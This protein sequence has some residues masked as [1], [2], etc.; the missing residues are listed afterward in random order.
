MWALILKLLPLLIKNL[1]LVI[2]VFA[3]LGKAL[4]KLKPA[5][6]VEIDG[7]SVANLIERLAEEAVTNIVSKHKDEITAW[8]RPADPEAQA[9]EERL[10]ELEKLLRDRQKE[11]EDTG[12]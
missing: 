2:A 10:D 6:E 9:R 11:Y 12:Q 3:G 8:V 1:P 7:E 4:D 5:P